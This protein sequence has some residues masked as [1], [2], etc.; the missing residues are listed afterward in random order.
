MTATINDSQLKQRGFDQL[1]IKYFHPFILNYIFS[2]C[3]VLNQ[4]IYFLMSLKMNNSLGMIKFNFF[5]EII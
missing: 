5:I 4:Q 3:K 2:I 1:M